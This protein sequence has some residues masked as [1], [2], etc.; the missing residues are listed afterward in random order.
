MDIHV[1]ATSQDG[2]LKKLKKL[3]KKKK[4]DEEEEGFTVGGGKQKNWA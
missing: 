3:K 4:K 1:A 2:K